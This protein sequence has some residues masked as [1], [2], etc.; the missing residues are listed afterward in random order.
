VKRTLAALS[1]I[2]AL[3]VVLSAAERPRATVIIIS[4]DGWRWD[5]HTK[6]PV[7][8]LR[9]LMARGIRAER[10]IPSFPTKTFPNHYTLVTGLYPG[11]H[12]VVG[13]SMRDPRTGRI[14]SMADRREVADPMWWGG[15]PIWVT[16]Q[17][18]GGKAAAMF[19]PGSEAP[20]NG[21]RPSLW[22][23]YDH[24]MPNDMRIDHMLRWLDLPESDR[25][26]FLTL[27]FSDADAAGHSFG[28]ESVELIRALQQIDTAL[29]RLLRGLAQRGL[30]DRINVIVTADHGMAETSRQRVVFID[31][32]LTMADGEV[33][34]LNPTVGVWPRPG[35]EDAVYR[36]LA[37]AHP[38]LTIYRRAN[39]PEH[40]HYREHERV[41]PIIGVADEGWSVMRRASVADAFR[42]S[43]R[44]V[45][46]NHGY[47]PHV[48]SMHTLFIAAG[49]AFRSNVVVPPFENVHVYETLCLVLGID[50][51]KNDGDRAVALSLLA[52]VASGGDRL[53]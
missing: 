50:P 37:T 51:L 30:E 34:D 16:L 45:G 10:L 6:A 49:P 4:L 31:D 36:K 47:D 33:V 32:Y 23:R 8:H 29:G 17:R 20:I 35:R 26:T 44:R 3:A 22:T 46:G 11:H 24:S 40:W 19:W 41:P 21:V 42:R 25:P 28:P 5:Y 38:R 43:V 14:F 48:R 15:E 7:P 27:Y 1:A 39:T 52:G 18:R 53:W 12:G 13:N 2:A 9:R